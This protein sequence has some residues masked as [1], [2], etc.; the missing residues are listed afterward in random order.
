MA[1]RQLVCLPASQIRMASP[2]TLDGSVW[3]KNNA[4]MQKRNNCP[5]G[6]S[7]PHWLMI[8]CQRMVSRNV[9]V[10]GSSK[11]NAIHRGSIWLRRLATVPILTQFKARYRSRP[12]MVSLMRTENALRIAWS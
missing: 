7:A 4:A 6:I 1:I 12:E 10:S 9:C 2:P 5:S 8:I 11:P 3:L